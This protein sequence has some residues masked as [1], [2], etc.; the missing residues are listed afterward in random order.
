MTKL[1]LCRIALREEG[2]YWNAY[3]APMGTMQ[4]AQL[5]ASLHMKHASN[6]ERKEE[7]KQLMQRCMNDF[8]RENFGLEASSF[9]TIDA[10]EHERT[11]E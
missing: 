4:G 9:D 1:A 6:Q 2:N 5:I 10:P 3:F 7:F 11:K 8:T